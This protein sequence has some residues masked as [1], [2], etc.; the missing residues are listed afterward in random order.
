LVREIFD[1]LENNEADI[2][3]SCTPSLLPS[4]RSASSNGSAFVFSN[5]WDKRGVTDRLEDLRPPASQIL[6]MWRT[7]VDDAGPFLQVLHVPTVTK[8]MQKCEGRIEAMES[9]MEPLV[10]AISMAA[11]YPL[12]REE[13]RQ[14]NSFLRDARKGHI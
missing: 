12:T 9:S 7:F 4:G 8:V 2:D 6:L 5:N 11:V 3:R 10:F 14:S 1:E 13:V